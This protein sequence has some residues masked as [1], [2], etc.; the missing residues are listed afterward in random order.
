MAVLAPRAETYYFADAG[1][2]TE[3][4]KDPQLKTLLLDWLGQHIGALKG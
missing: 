3:M 1:H 4:F 2:G